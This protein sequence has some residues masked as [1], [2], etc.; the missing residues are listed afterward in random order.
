MRR[1]QAGHPGCSC[2]VRSTPRCDLLHKSMQILHR[3]A[4]GGG[5]VVRERLLASSDFPPV[6]SARQRNPRAV[7]APSGHSAA[8]PDAPSAL[9]F[10][11]TEVGTRSARTP[12][13][14]RRK[15]KSALPV[16]GGRSPDASS[17]LGLAA[18]G[19]TRC[20]RLRSASCGHHTSS[21]LIL[22]HLS[23]HR[24]GRSPAPPWSIAA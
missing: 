20:I 24:L 14:I 15:S 3:S 23:E 21:R 12:S 11:A 13:G 4:N 19:H 22:A 6:R 2:A 8:R 5:R 18:T 1:P 7:R 16:E 17:P 10:G 9:V